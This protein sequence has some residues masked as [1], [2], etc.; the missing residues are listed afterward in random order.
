M[1]T[2]RAGDVGTVP[3]SLGESSES[4]VLLLVLLG[5]VRWSWTMEAERSFVA[6]L[7]PLSFGLVL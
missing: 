1:A 2:K 4:A 5:H 6:P 7:E 3:V